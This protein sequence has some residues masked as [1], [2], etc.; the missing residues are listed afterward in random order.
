MSLRSIPHSAATS[1]ITRRSAPTSSARPGIA[2][3]TA[4]V[5][6][7]SSYLEAERDACATDEPA[8]LAAASDDPA[9][10]DDVSPDCGLTNSSGTRSQPNADF[11][12]CGRSTKTIVQLRAVHVP[13]RPAGPSLLRRSRA[14]PAAGRQ[15]IAPRTPAAPRRRDERRDAPSATAGPRPRRPKL[16]H[17]PST[18]SGSRRT[19][20]TAPGGYFTPPLWA[21]DL[22][23]PPPLVPV[24]S[25]SAPHP[26][27]VTSC[28]EASP[29]QRAQL[30]TGVDVQAQVPEHR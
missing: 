17:H 22:I 15:L 26:D 18:S 24:G 2:R 25:C 12:P 3:P 7:Y 20:P 1:D 23:P 19:P 10:I 13:P 28:L 27:A 4:A 9:D 11:T 8:A 29:R 16:E 6:P 14:H 21:I 30:T 5:G